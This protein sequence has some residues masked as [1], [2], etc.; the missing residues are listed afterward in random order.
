MSM[1]EY[2]GYHGKVEF[3]KEDVCLY[4]KILGINA[5][6]TF[7]SDDPKTIE[8]AF[9][10]CVDHYL[11]LCERNGLTPEKEYSG[12]LSIRIRPDTHRKLCLLAMSEG[13]SLNAAISAACDHF[14]EDIEAN[15]NVPSEK[16]AT[17]GVQRDVVAFTA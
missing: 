6:V 7:E 2:K 3:N 11:D 16:R 8:Q 9:R 15:H 12:Q 17:N 13:K 4:G 1:L 5:L 14:V 10:D